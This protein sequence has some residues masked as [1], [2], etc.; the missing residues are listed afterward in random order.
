MGDT[1]VMSE[2]EAR[3]LQYYDAEF[4]RRYCRFK[5]PYTHK[6]ITSVQEYLDALES[7]QLH[8]SVVTD[9]T[10]SLPELQKIFA[11]KF[12]NCKNPRTGNAI[13]GISD[14]LEAM[15][16]QT[17]LNTIKKA[18]K[19]RD[20]IEA[21]NEVQAR[22]SALAKDAEEKEKAK[23]EELKKQ[24]AAFKKSERQEK[25]KGVLLAVVGTIVG[26]IVWIAAIYILSFL[27]ALLQQVP[28]L[29]NIL[30]WPSDISFVSSATINF[31]S[32]MIAVVAAE[33]IGNKL[34]CKVF[35]GALLCLIAF[36]LISNISY[37]T[38]TAAG[39]IANI[40][41]GVAALLLFSDK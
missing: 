29:S 26:F 34:G 41:T 20:E 16:E 40:E 6:P 18:E 23:I 19:Q 24:E 1:V 17:R 35:G 15:D 25:A 31:G 27:F 21:R 11:E 3:L 10:L 12:G 39:A 14:Y 8:R 9:R 32:V 38:L 30:F 13:Q 37:G 7:M 2:E 28:I 22:T 36:A 5:H 33:K 4:A